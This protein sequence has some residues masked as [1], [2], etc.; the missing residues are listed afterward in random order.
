MTL[1]KKVLLP[2]ALFSALLVGY[3][4]GYWIPRSLDTIGDNY[5]SV[6]GRHLDSVVEGLVPLLLAHQLDTIYGNLDALR[7]KNRDWVGIELRDAKGRLLYPLSEASRPKT[8][9]VNGEV[10]VLKRRIDYLGENLGALSVAI[11]FGPWLRQAQT[12]QHELV[13]VLLAGIGAFFLT[14]GVLLERLV[15]QPVNALSNAATALAQNRFEG[16]LDKSGDDEV[17]NLVDRFA[18]MREAIRGYQAALRASEHEFRTLAEN[19]PDVIA[20]YDTAGTCLYVN[21]KF[22]RVHGLSSQDV[23]GKTPTG[24][25]GEW[26][27]AAAVFTEKLTAATASGEGASLDLS[28]EKD[29][30]RV[31]WFVRIV[32][33]FVEDGRVVSALTIWSDITKR[34]EAMY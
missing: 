7:A 12:R 8:A 10:H 20:R 26:G 3:L 2:L 14:A 19:A 21:P 11:D 30:K 25:P 33:E 31:Y 16:P 22:E 4:Y 17:G 18:E 13:V 27:P 9:R 32:P 34:R 24:L 1:R 6:T 5:K 23:I 29:G 28:W 15:L